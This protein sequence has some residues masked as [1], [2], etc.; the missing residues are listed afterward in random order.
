VIS[1]TKGS[2]SARDIRIRLR[3]TNASGR[4]TGL[5]ADGAVASSANAVFK[6]ACASLIN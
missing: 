3:S 6:W 2:L 4:N 5:T 1:L